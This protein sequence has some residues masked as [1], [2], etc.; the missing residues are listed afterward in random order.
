MQSLGS[1]GSNFI[2]ASRVV[3]DTGLW[4]GQ[5]ATR[6]IAGPLTGVCTVCN[7]LQP[8]GH[9]DTLGR[10]PN[11]LGRR[12]R[13]GSQQRTDII[14]TPALSITDIKTKE[15]L[16]CRDINPKTGKPFRDC[17]YC[18]LLCDIFD[19]FFVD[20]YM[21]W[22]T[23]TK[24]GMHLDVG[25]MIR[26]GAPL[27]VNCSGCFIYDPTMMHPRADLEIYVESSELLETPGVPTMGLTLPRVMDTTHPSCMQFVKD[28]IQQCLHE[29][30][31]CVKS[32]DDFMP[33][34]LLYL[35]SG[36]DSITLCDTFPTSVSWAALSH[37]WG[38]SK[39]LKLIKSNL[40]D[41][42]QSIPLAN[43]PATFNNAIQ[44]CRELSI[45]YLWIDSL[46]IIQDDQQEWEKES[47]MMGKIYSYA[48]LVIIAAS[49]DTPDTPFLGP[50]GEDWDVKMFDFETP[51]GTHVPL[52][53]RRRHLLAAP[54][55][56]GQYEPPFTESWSRLR[57]VG[58][59]YKRGW[60]FQESHL[61]SR[62]LH[63]APGSLIFECRTHR[64]S[65]D[66]PPPYALVS[67]GSLGEVTDDR[68]WRLIVESYTSR[69]L[70]FGSDKLP[71]VS[72]VAALMP[73]AATSEYLAGL[74]STSLLADL[75]WHVMPTSN[76][77][78]TVMTYPPGQQSAPSWSWAS[79]DHG[80]IWNRLETFEP[81]ASVIGWD[82]RAV[83]INR[84]GTVSS[85]SIKIRGRLKPCLVKHTYQKGQQH[86]YT[87]KPDGSRSKEQWFLGDGQ[88]VPVKS[89]KLQVP[90]CRRAV[91][92]M[93]TTLEHNCADYEGAGAFFLCL[94]RTGRLEYGYV[95]LMLTPVE[96]KVLDGW[97]E[98]VGVI[99]S[100]G[101]EWYD[102]GVETVVTLV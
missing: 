85:G 8:Y 29:H 12:I 18:R 102:D 42:K 37:R 22:I 61:A 66:T 54:I 27:V 5:W 28:C 30:P 79:I 84:F 64:R 47:E 48:F 95:G 9:E 99:M 86:A 97:M 46:C 33:T 68:K 13:Q 32:P 17:R 24:C 60:C 34:R 19:A 81:L 77:S 91:A 67:P 45:S 21:S 23:D 73:Q 100:L 78:T 15:L 56:Q 82:C 71:A 4:L 59:L 31:L 1:R 88:I 40:D 93:V 74:W 35:D 3:G 63:F 44:V 36:G 38:D 16:K 92:G 49:S 26:E 89:N 52:K 51:S 50:R 69:K 96:G 10:T 25:L 90:F 41:L 43:L 14:N 94:A 2:K 75:L 65:D 101:S 70:S 87:V 6:M 11:S 98:R 58:P 57:R 80:I 20:E 39:P 72:G 62:A 83:G 55:D 53:V 7:N 76:R